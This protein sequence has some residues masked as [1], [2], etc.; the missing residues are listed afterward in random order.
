MKRLLLL[1][2]SGMG[3]THPG[4]H[5]AERAGLMEGLVAQLTR[6][7]QCLSA[8][9][10]A[11]PNSFCGSSHSLGENRHIAGYKLLCRCSQQNNVICF[12]GSLLTVGSNKLDATEPSI[13]ASSCFKDAFCLLTVFTGK[14]AH[15]SRFPGP[16]QR[17]ERA[18]CSRMRT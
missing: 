4:S 13:L 3:F 8:A 15:L 11:A 7:T 12:L 5:R 16:E 10:C 2:A 14:A 6:E 1:Q 17:S 9:P 18:F